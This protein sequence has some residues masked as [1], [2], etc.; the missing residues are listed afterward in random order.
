MKVTLTPSTR[1]ENHYSISYQVEE[2]LEFIASEELINKRISCFQYSDWGLLEVVQL[3][4]NDYEK[5]LEVRKAKQLS[6]V[7]L[8]D[9]LSLKFP[10][11]TV[12]SVE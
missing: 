2:G 9:K 5:A 11:L 10:L 6:I 3:I 4:N 7:A 8:I 12:E 1:Y